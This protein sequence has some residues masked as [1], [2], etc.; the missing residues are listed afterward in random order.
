MGFPRFWGRV[1]NGE[2]DEVD[3]VEGKRSDRKANDGRIGIL[4]SFAYYILLVVG[5]TSWWKYLWPLTESELS[6][7]EF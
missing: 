2:E 7:T 5:A 4:W 1:T 3:L 6:L